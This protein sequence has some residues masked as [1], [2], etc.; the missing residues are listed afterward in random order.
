MGLRWL[1]ALV[2]VVVFVTGAHADEIGGARFTLPDGWT[3][4][5]SEWVARRGAESA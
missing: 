1:V 3:A 4:L 5:R 2:V